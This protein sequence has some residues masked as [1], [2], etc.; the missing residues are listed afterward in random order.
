MVAEMGFEK[1]VEM[2]SAN[3][4]QSGRIV[5]AYRLGTLGSATPCFADFRRE[6]RLLTVFHSS[7]NEQRSSSPYHEVS[8]A[9]SRHRDQKERT[10]D[11]R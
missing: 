9:Q 10:Q 1:A 4:A 11:T 8:G 6:K 7:P 5:V 2:R 3:I